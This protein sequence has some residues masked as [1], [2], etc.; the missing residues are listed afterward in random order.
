MELGEEIFERLAIE[1]Q[2]LYNYSSE[3]SGWGRKETSQDTFPSLSSFI[4][5]EK[6]KHS[7]F[8]NTIQIQMPL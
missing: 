1:R 3:E 4:V 2:V 8:G 7:H 5:F 6:H